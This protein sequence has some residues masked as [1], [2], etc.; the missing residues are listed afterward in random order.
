ML[1]IMG[2]QSEA[3][4]ISINHTTQRY[5]AAACITIY[6]QVFEKYDHLSHSDFQEFP[7]FDPGYTIYQLPNRIVSC[8]KKTQKDSVKKCEKWKKNCER[9]LFLKAEPFTKSNILRIGTN[10][11]ASPPEVFCFCSSAFVAHLRMNREFNN[12]WLLQN[13]S[14]E[15]LQLLYSFI[16][17]SIEKNFFNQLTSFW[18][19]N[20]TFTLFECS[21]VH[22]KAASVNRTWKK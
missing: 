6:R 20:L 21:S 13:R 16:W 15:H 14:G 9:Q 7:G 5:S 18:M 19:V 4:H 1:E 22:T 2:R 3:S 10:L 11:N 8:S 17:K 12:E